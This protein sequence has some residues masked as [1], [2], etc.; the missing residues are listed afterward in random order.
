MYPQTSASPRIKEAYQNEIHRRLISAVKSLALEV[1]PPGEYFTLKSG[2]KSPYYLDCRLLNLDPAGLFTVVEALY[3]NLESMEFDCIGGPSIGA[4]PIVGGLI[5]LYG[6]HAVQRE[7]K[8]KGF[9]VRSQSK[10][11]GKSD[12]LVGDVRKG[13]KCIIVEDVITTGCSSF[14]SILEV[15]KAGATVI[16]V[17]SIVDRLQGGGKLFEERKIPYKSLLTIKDLGIDPKS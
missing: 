14:E 1:K 17:I 13:D 2:A 5:Y 3:W 10:D 7:Q 9:M 4:D 15:E 6:S 11:H 8:I 12:K 16:Q